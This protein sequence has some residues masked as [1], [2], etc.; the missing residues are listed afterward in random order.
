MNVLNEI[1]DPHSG[2]GSEKYYHTSRTHIAKVMA[3]LERI[4][5]SALSVMNVDGPSF[6]DTVGQQNR[7]STGK[8]SVYL[9]EGIWKK[10][11]SL[12]LY[13][14]PVCRLFSRTK[15]AVSTE[16][17][18]SVGTSDLLSTESLSVVRTCPSL[19]RP[20]SRK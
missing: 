18:I 2:C 6:M 17:A 19:L 4:W 8:H 10:D 13:W 7:S 5:A 14:L 11:D 16:L 9:T 20:F 15:L 12:H 3:D 1:K